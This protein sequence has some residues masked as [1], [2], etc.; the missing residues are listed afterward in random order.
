MISTKRDAIAYS[1]KCVGAV[2]LSTSYMVEI[3]QSHSHKGNSKLDQTKYI[4]EKWDHGFVDSKMVKLLSKV[5]AFC[6]EKGHVIMD[7]HFMPFH[8][9]AYIV[10]HVEL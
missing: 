5:C 8:I 3:P 4:V 2:Y 9:R 1:P 6:E 7:C 10:R